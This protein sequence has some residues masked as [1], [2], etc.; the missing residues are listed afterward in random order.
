M[1]THNYVVLS[2][3]KGNEATPVRGAA[4]CPAYKTEREAWEYAK[5]MSKAYPDTHYIV[6]QETIIYTNGEGFE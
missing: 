3:L 4:S 2:C 6:Y 5:K 1:F